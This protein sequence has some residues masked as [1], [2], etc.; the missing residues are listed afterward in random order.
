MG[1]KRRSQDASGTFATANQLLLLKS[2]GVAVSDDIT[3]AEASKLIDGIIR[4]GLATERQKSYLEFM[5]LD[6]PSS[7]TEDQAAALIGNIPD[8][9]YYLRKKEKW[10]EIRDRRERAERA[11]IRGKPLERAKAK[12][13][14]KGISFTKNISLPDAEELLQGGAPTD[15]QL[16]KATAW[17][18][19]VKANLD[20]E[21]L[22]TILEKIEGDAEEILA[23]RA[24]GGLD[25]QKAIRVVAYAYNQ[26]PTWW[27]KQDMEVN[28][29]AINKCA[30]A[31]RILYPSCYRG[32][33]E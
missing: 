18:V 9:D 21:S 4:K 15:E 2:K 10:A 3:K 31:I 16:E 17:G 25:R 23:W 5:G 20:K 30:E 13:T 14:R 27:L 12:L 26:N 22:Q 29:K 11:S 19:N 8:T 24:M 32:T 7:L 33:A 1:K 28:I 6:V